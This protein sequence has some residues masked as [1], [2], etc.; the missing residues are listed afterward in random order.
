[1]D[2]SLADFTAKL[3]HYLQEAEQG[4]TF[5]I[6][7]GDRQV[8]RLLP[9]EI[10]P[11]LERC[12]FGAHSFDGSDTSNQRFSKLEQQLDH[13]LDIVHWFRRWGSPWS[14]S[15]DL[16][17]FAKQQGYK[18]LITWLPRNRVLWD[19]VAG[20][21]NA[22]IDAWALALRDTNYPVYVR[23]F[24]EMNLQNADITWQG[25]PNWLI[26]AWRH[27]VNRFR[28]LG[29]SNVLWVWS[30]NRS[31]EPKTLNNRLEKYYPGSQFVD[32]LAVDGYNFGNTS[33]SWLS[34]EATFTEPYERITKLD[35]KLP[36]WITETAC[37]EDPSNSKAQWIRD[38]FASRAFPKL[39]ALVWFDEKKER[40]WRINSSSTAVAAFKESFDS[41]IV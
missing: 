31:D 16:M 7:S 38:M 29:A 3:N 1:M 2:I 20:K 36:F 28:H 25:Q 26:A 40:D 12:L 18:P 15:A 24:P 33:H 10:L 21:H 22:D 8:A 19:I 6:K 9:P 34:F 11:L 30:P 4:K 23:P 5:L 17:A 27:T 14:D 39:K 32:V 13:K 37:A 41:V 35:P